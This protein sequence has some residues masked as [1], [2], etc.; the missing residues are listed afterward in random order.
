MLVVDDDPSVRK[1]LT[2]LLESSGYAVNK[3]IAAAPTRWA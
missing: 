3:Q 1:G 2:R